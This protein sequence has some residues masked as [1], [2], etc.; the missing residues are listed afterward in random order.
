MPVSGPEPPSL[1][2]PPWENVYELH[3]CVVI[4][5]FRVEW[6][7]VAQAR[8]DRTTD[9]LRRRAAG[10]A[11]NSMSQF[12]RRPAPH[13]PKVRA[14]LTLT[15]CSASPRLADA[16][17]VCLQRF[18]LVIELLNFFLKRVF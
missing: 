6:L 4:I 7:L 12:V 9:Q 5:L 1:V 14:E 17:Q 2:L 11:I 16:S 3:A 8:P 13:F 15:L 18:S 10:V